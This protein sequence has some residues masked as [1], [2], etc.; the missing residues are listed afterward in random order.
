[1]SDSTYKLIAT[2]YNRMRDKET[3]CDNLVSN[4]QQIINSQANENKALSDK[5]KLLQAD[6]NIANDE[7]EH[8]KDLKRIIASF[9]A[10]L[11]V[12]ILIIL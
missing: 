2:E 9:G 4:H 12:V 3:V 1:M 8:Q 6:L 10:G 11:I 5:N 7:I